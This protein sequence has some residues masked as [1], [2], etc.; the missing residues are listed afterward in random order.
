VAGAADPGTPAVAAV[1]AVPTAEVLAAQAGLV[2]DL[3]AVKD[4]LYAPYP[5]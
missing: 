1:D 5:D 3:D 4:V 2:T